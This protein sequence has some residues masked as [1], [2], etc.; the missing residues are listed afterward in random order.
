MTFMD[1]LAEAVEMQPA[2][3]PVPG[4][5]AAATPIRRGRGRPPGSTDRTPRVR[6]STPGSDGRRSGRLRR[7]AGV[8]AAA[9]DPPPLEAV[10]EDPITTPSA[11]TNTTGRKRRR[12]QFV[13]DDAADPVADGQP[14]EE[15]PL[16]DYGGPVSAVIQRKRLKEGVT[17]DDD[18]KVKRLQLSITVSALGD[19]LDGQQLLPARVSMAHCSLR[20]RHLPPALQC[21]RNSDCYASDRAILSI[22]D[23]GSGAL[24]RSGYRTKSEAYR[25]SLFHFSC[26]SFLSFVGVVSFRHASLGATV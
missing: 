10:L 17:A 19:D 14:D 4:T 18:G 23:L 12:V 20:A 25:I 8:A 2:G 3:A 16:E 9:T 21:V 15:D 26:L 1:M 13:D 22:G 11:A 7:N 5:A 24:Q 6:R